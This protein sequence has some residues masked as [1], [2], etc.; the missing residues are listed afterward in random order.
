MTP[1]FLCVSENSSMNHIG[2]EVMAWGGITES[3]LSMRTNAENGKK[4]KSFSK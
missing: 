2:L 1:S 4:E 3:C